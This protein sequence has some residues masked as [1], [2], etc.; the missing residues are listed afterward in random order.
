MI[1]VH[2]LYMLCKEI[3]AIKV[4]EDREVGIGWLAHITTP[5]AKFDMLRIY[6]MPPS[7]VP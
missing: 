2:H 5:E 6:M 1:G 7:Y 3:F 4:F